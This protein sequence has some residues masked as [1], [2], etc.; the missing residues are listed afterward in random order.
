MEYKS[1]EVYCFEGVHGAGKT[2]L[3]NDLKKKGYN[4]LDEGFIKTPSELHPQS[5]VMEFEW[6]A[7]WF[8]RLRE[9]ASKTKSQLFITDRSPYSSIFYTRSGDGGL[10]L[11]L[12]K[13]L[14][15]ELEKTLNIHIHTVFL[16]TP[17]GVLWERINNRLVTEQNR[18]LFGE[19]DKEWLQKIYD[20]Y[21][22]FKW[23]YNV[24]PENHK[25]SDMLDI[26]EAVHYYIKFL[27]QG[28][29]PLMLPSST[30]KKRRRRKKKIKHR[31]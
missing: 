13:T 29:T 23:D 8:K 9:L 28:G 2:T 27:E 20:K 10:F 17:L 12:I 7:A 21:M 3:I 25:L 16:W 18:K 15:L 19:D 30:K 14:S 11:D 5:F 24:S 31:I 26:I 4:T 6:I 1:I 22:N